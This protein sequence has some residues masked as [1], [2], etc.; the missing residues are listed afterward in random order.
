MG[1]FIA[2]MVFVGGLV[3]IRSLLTPTI[4]MPILITGLIILLVAVGLFVKEISNI[5]GGGQS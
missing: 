2:G 4:N 1:K 5:G 3:V